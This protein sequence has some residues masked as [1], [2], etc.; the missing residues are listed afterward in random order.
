MTLVFDTS[1][2]IDI[3]R[4]DK[5]TLEKIKELSEIHPAP[6]SI[7]F[8]S[9]FEFFHGLQVKSPKNKG[10]ALAFIEFFHFLEPTKRTARILSD[11]RYKYEKIG[12]SFSLSDLL[13][14]SQTIENGMTLVTS[15]KHFQELEELKKVVL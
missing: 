12:M 1:V 10:K 7:T 8:I 13:I 11:L 2:L 4:K 14:A 5:R 3:Q 9:Y 6:A 15:D